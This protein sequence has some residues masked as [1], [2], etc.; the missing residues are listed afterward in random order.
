M[1]KSNITFSSVKPAL[2]RFNSCE[3]VG[4]KIHVLDKKN[5]DK[6]K[7]TISVFDNTNADNPKKNIKKNSQNKSNSDTIPGL[8]RNLQI[9]RDRFS[10]QE[11]NNVRQSINQI[12]HPIIQTNE[13]K[14]NTTKNHEQQNLKYTINHFQPLQKSQIK[15]FRSPEELLLEF[16]VD[17]NIPQFEIPQKLKLTTTKNTENPEQNC[18]NTTNS[19]TDNS[20]S[21]NLKSD[22][23]EDDKLEED[24][25]VVDKLIDDKLIN[26]KLIN[27]ALRVCGECDGADVAGDV[28]QEVIDVVEPLLSS[29]SSASAVSNNVEVDRES[30]EK[31]CG[32]EL[33]E[34]GADVGGSVGDVGVG[35]GDVV[36]ESNEAVSGEND[37]GRE[38]LCTREL[39]KSYVK[40]KLKIP[41]LNGANFTAYCGEFVSITGQSGS[42]KSTL[43]HLLGA[44]DKPDSGE[45][46]FDGVRIDNLS[47]SMR[48]RLRNRKIGFI[49]Q[50]YNLLPEFTA[51]ENVLSP[52]MIRDGVLRYFFRRR[53]YISRG[54]ELLRRVGLMHRIKH[55]PSELSGGEIQRVAIARSLIIEPKLLLADEPTG[56]LDSAS[57]KEVI[58]ILRELNEENNLTIVMVTHDKSI[59]ASADRIVKMSD[60]IIDCRTET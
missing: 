12:I 8:L 54:V 28:W 36:C 10:P 53:E 21:D 39:T 37:L 55:K 41:V 45:I 38:L 27:D 34:H 46:F 49:F 30:C 25:D 9:F 13:T 57:A 59:A 11:I 14:N 33:H 51:L 26:L 7:R 2:E 20:T 4:T 19:T 52:L 58:K 29:L 1:K 56:N 5:A 23:L 24:D 15:T 16:S 50:F 3:I 6:P 44:L 32:R 18:P 42:G 48:D 43:M 35:V 22:N 60:G 17:D 40:G 31:E 47:S